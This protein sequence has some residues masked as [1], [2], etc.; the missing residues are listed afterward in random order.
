[1]IH[2]ALHLFRTIFSHVYIW[3]PSKLIY[4]GC[5]P[6]FGK[7][8]PFLFQ[9]IFLKLEYFFQNLDFYFD[10]VKPTALN[11][12]LSFSFN[13]FKLSFFVFIFKIM[14]FLSNIHC[15]LYSFIAIFQIS[16]FISLLTDFLSFF[17]N[18]LNFLTY[19]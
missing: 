2:I 6:I 9:T 1:M 10:K 7:T 3:I 4:F 15:P 8:K 18:C 11:F 16:I 13:P 19:P 5:V 12:I 17:S 14:F